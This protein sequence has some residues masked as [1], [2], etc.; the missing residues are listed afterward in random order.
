MTDAELLRRFEDS[1]LSGDDFTHPRHVRVAWLYLET[2]HRDEALE[3]MADGL[4]RLVTCL[5]KPDKFDYS[6][7]RAWIDKI[8]AARTSH[9][10]ARSFEELIAACPSLLDRTTVRSGASSR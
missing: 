8:D 4:R 3:R 9:P 1:S 7:T 5:G 6:L 10:E 2:Y